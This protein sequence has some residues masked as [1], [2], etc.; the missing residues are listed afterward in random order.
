[1]DRVQ[2][3]C[4]V[5]SAMPEGW[6]SVLLLHG[7]S[8]G[9]RWDRATQVITVPSSPGSDL[10][11]SVGEVPGCVAR[12]EG[13]RGGCSSSTGKLRMLPELIHFLLSVLGYLASK[14]TCTMRSA[15]KN[16]WKGKSP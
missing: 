4:K 12:K 16:N 3:G 5:G 9:P 7:V 13:W 10:H 14:N 11:I 2:P 8:Q 1:M 15:G 6:K